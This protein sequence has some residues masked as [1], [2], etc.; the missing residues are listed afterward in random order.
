[1][2]VAVVVVHDDASLPHIW[3]TTLVLHLSFP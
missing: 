3:Q 1:M 2:E